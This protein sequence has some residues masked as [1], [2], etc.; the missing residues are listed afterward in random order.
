[1]NTEIII[2][3]AIA[4]V[5][6]GVIGLE[7]EYRAKEAGFRTHFLV[8]LGSAL[9]M[10]LSQYGCLEL[11]RA[12]HVPD[13][14]DIRLDPSRIAS[15]VVSGIG[16]IGAGAIILQK[17]MVRG[18]TTAAG[19]WVAA[20]IGMA[21]GAGM[22]VV[23]VVATLLVLL[24]LEAMN[25]VLRRVGMRNVV[26][27]FSASSE[28]DAQEVLERIHEA[29]VKISSYRMERKRDGD[30]AEKVEATVEMRVRRISYETRILAL[31]D[32]FNGVTVED[33]E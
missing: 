6:G 1:M 11:L 24:C 33:V 10:V 4:A 27:R 9:F 28:H 3:L 32:D 15:Q 29:H 13:G 23:A 30:G 20:A 12:N 26:V 18:L 31:L 19:L 21:C 16:F 5:L 8:A 25:F 22:H 2:R 17:H 14:L 7:R